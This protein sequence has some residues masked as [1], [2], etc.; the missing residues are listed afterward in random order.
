VLVRGYIL[1]PGFGATLPDEVKQR[2]PAG[3]MAFSMRL[4]FYRG[5]TI[6][7]GQHQIIFSGE[8]DCDFITRWGIELPGLAGSMG[9][10]VLEPG[11]EMHEAAGKWS[12]TTPA[13]RLCWAPL[14]GRLAPVRGGFALI[15]QGWYDRP[16]AITQEGGSA[17][18]DF[19]PRAAGVW[20]LR[21]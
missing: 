16:A 7:T 8:P 9:T 17:W 21:R 20:D 5:T 3:R 4:S 18:V 1:L 12:L 15:R 11:A 6:V 10:L 14:R 2:E 19:W 13:T